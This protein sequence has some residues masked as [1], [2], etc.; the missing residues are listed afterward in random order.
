MSGLAG[1][2][3][4][5]VA[6]VAGVALTTGCRTTA[7]PSD[8]PGTDSARPA[9]ST[10]AAVLSF[11]PADKASQVRLDQQVA[12]H[13]SGGRLTG[14][15]ATRTGGVVLTGILAGDGSGWTSAESLAPGSSY[16]VVATA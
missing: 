11:Q 3:R 13:V 1:R 5:V 15:T 4:V 12:V 10:P 2:G 14:V 8:H 16:T 6:L 7:A 9:A